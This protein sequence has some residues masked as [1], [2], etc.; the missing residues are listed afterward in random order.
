MRRASQATDKPELLLPSRTPA[1]AGRGCLFFAARHP[2]TISHMLE[3]RCEAPPDL[4]PRRRSREGAI[5]SCGRPTQGKLAPVAHDAEVLPCLGHATDADKENRQKQR[6]PYW[7][8]CAASKPP[9]RLRWPAGPARAL[10][11]DSPPAACAPRAITAGRPA[12]GALAKPCPP[13]WGQQGQG[14]ERSPTTRVRAG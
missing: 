13:P 11:G 12:L 14:R 2:S 8:A 6:P 10:G 3:R 1:T 4:S 5:R 7:R 9:P